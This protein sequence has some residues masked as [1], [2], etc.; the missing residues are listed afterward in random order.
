MLTSV[1]KALVRLNNCLERY[2]KLVFCASDIEATFLKIRQS[3]AEGGQMLLCGN[4]GSAADADHISGELLKG[5]GHPRPIRG[6][7]RE[8]LG[9]ELANNLQGSLPA[10]PLTVFPA[11]KTAYANDCN[12]DYTFAQLTWGLG[13]PGDM[14][15]GISTSGNSRN[16]LLAMEVAKAK[17]LGTIGLTGE[18]GGK[19]KSVVDT[20]ICVPET[21]VYKIQELHLPI[22][23]TLC[24]MLE[25]AF[26]ER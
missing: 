18:S 13:R 11:L 8:K 26:F 12:A 20:C 22:Y 7:W 5:F 24:L 4:G 3:Y 17:G 6:E 9:S 2:P 10:I 25:D 14:L 23:H 21:E 15:F 1:D 16:V 19:L